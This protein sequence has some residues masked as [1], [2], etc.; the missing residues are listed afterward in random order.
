V[1][2]LP[3][4]EVLLDEFEILNCEFSI[5]AKLAKIFD[6]ELVWQAF[7]EHPAEEFI[8]PMGLGRNEPI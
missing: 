4:R 7:G 8:V 5:I 1:S 3:S 6:K 2:I